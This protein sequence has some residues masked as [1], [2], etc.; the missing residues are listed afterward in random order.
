MH[1]TT[2]NS[3][4]LARRLGRTSQDI[5]RREVSTWH[6]EST[7]R[8]RDPSQQSPSRSKKLAKHNRPLQRWIPQVRVEWRPRSDRTM[9]SGQSI[10]MHT[11]GGE[12]STRAGPRADVEADVERAAGILGSATT[13]TRKQTVL[14]LQ[15]PTWEKSMKANVGSPLGDSFRLIL[16]MVIVGINLGATCFQ[17]HYVKD[18][19]QLTSAGLERFFILGVSIC[20]LP[21][22]PC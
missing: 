2:A 22:V 6:T 11:I 14:Q 3:D 17:F 16:R 19:I 20:Q 7:I 13:I 21:P 10:H 8:T 5:L 15:E 18:S 12:P 9:D 1:F 4:N